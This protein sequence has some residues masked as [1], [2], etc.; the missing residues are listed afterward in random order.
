MK[1]IDVSSLYSEMIM[2]TYT[3]DLIQKKMIYLYLC[4]YA[5][6]KPNLTLLAINTL[7]RDCRDDDPMVRGLAL[8]S[9][10]SLKC[11]NLTEYIYEPIKNGLKDK[12]NYVRKTAVIGISKIYKINK[13]IIIDN[14]FI[15][16]LYNMISDND[17]LVVINVIYTLNEILQHEVCILWY[18]LLYTLYM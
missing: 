1:G 13:D 16:I 14:D 4:N 11:N 2:A 7:Q 12:N 10:C 3:S 9:I 15:D 6:M 5:R 8:R 17:C 18:I